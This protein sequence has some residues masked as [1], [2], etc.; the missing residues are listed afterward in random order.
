M[1]DVTGQVNI[2]QLTKLPQGQQDSGALPFVLQPNNQVPFAGVAAGA[3]AVVIN[4]I[5]TGLIAAGIMKAS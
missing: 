5:V 1:A 4:L 3:D 2:P